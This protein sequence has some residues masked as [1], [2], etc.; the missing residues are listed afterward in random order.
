[1]TRRDVYDQNAIVY[2]VLEQGLREVPRSNLAFFRGEAPL[3]RL[4]VPSATPPMD[5]PGEQLVEWGG[6][7][8]WLRSQADALVMREAALRAGGHATLF[9]GGDKSLGVFQPLAP[10]LRTIHRRLKAE[11]DPHA[12]FNRGRMYADL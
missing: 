2:A 11:F 12:V 10:V 5:L 6:S 3:W 7:L 8:R 1:L 9:R 4:S